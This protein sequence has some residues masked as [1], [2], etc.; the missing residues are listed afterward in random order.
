MND[1]A[2]SLHVHGQKYLLGEIRTK[3][4]SNIQLTFLFY[5]LAG[6]LRDVLGS[7]Q[8][9]YYIAGGMGIFFSTLFE[10]QQ[11]LTHHTKFLNNRGP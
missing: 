6:L 10:L 9:A 4:L 2:I 11:I 5:F 8:V 7:Y 3:V 1:Q